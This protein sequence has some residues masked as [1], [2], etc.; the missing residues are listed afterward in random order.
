MVRINDG[1]SGWIDTGGP[2]GPRPGGRL[3]LL[4][5]LPVKTPLRTGKLGSFFVSVICNGF[6]ITVNYYH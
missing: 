2:S 4:R 6:L 5:E 3:R 1:V